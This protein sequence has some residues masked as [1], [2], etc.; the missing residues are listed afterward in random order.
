MAKVSEYLLTYQ[1]DNKKSECSLTWGVGGPQPDGHVHGGVSQNF[2]YFFA[3]NST[4]HYSLQKPATI[5]A[6]AYIR[7][8]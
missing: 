4:A 2:F 8:R 1:A 3:H 7:Y 5:Q 6:W